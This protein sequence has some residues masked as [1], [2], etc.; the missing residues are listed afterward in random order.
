M[1]STRKWT[2]YLIAA[3]VMAIILVEGASSG[4]LFRF[5]SYKQSPFTPEGT[6]T[7]FLIIKAL[8]LLPVESYESDK[9]ELFRA[10]SVLGY[11]TNPGT[12]RIVD[13]IG[14]KKHGYHVTITDAG[15]RA[16]SYHSNTASRRIYIFG[17]STIWAMG[18]DDEMTV[19]WLLQARLP[20]YHVINLASTGY[21]NVQ[22]LLQ[23][24]R[25]RDQLHPDDIV[26]FNYGV[27]NLPAN[28]ADPIWIRTLS[29]G[30]EMSLRG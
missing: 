3:L 29:H 13:T 24:R 4:F 26:V 8:G 2:I 14:R 21:S 23:Y 27:Q 20:D 30:Y 5:Y 11:T 22:Q 16:T 18:L 7:G 19:P 1:L 9:P 10:D 6:A 25:I 12:Y 28:V 15:V 17:N